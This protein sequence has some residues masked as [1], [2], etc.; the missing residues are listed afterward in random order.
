MRGAF[1]IAAEKNL[2]NEEY[3]RRAV[4]L[5]DTYGM[6]YKIKRNIKPDDL[7]K[8]MQVDKKVLSGKIRFVLPISESEVAIFDD[9]TKEE[10]ISTVKILY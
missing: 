1:Y 8:A 3:F 5:L 10:I 9:I 2:I 6:D 4:K 7:Y